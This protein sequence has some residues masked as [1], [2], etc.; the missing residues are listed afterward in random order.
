MNESASAFW[1]MLGSPV[2]GATLADWNN[3][4]WMSG[5][6]GSNNPG[7]GASVYYYDVDSV[8]VNGDY[9]LGYVV[10]S[11]IT[12]PLNATEGWLVWHGGGAVTTDVTGPLNTGSIGTGSLAYTSNPTGG[13][14]KRGWHLLSNPYAAP[15]EWVNVTKN[16]C[17][18]K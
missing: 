18:R 3:E 11:G 15:V 7:F 10:P 12:E 1:Y 17:N 14:T 2:S 16:N 8:P 4:L 9:G 5:F 13:P 6:P